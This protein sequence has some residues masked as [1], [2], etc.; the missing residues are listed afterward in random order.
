MK[1][2]RNFV[3]NFKQMECDRKRERVRETLWQTGYTSQRV[4][5]KNHHQE[6]HQQDGI[7]STPLAL[8]VQHI[9]LDINWL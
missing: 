1:A 2:E 6:Q 4:H 5:A 9:V 3:Y 8:I 7:C